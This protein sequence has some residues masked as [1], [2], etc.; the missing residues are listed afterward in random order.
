[1]NTQHAPILVFAFGNPSRGD[2][3]LG[4]DLYA[5]LEK[6]KQDDHALNDVDLLIDFQLQIEHT[7]DLEQRKAIIFIDASVSCESPFEFQPLWP[8][9]DDSYTSHAMS[10]AAVL[11]VYQQIHQYAPPPSYL[12]TVRGYQFN[13][14]DALSSQARTN[15]QQA[16]DFSKK[17][18]SLDIEQWPDN[19]SQ[20]A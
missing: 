15:L 17:L 11:A 12:L 18:L 5:L 4:P 1:M 2:D 10:P 20:C 7:T 8:Q 6:N 9:R 14:G 16:Y 13:L 3:A 19:I